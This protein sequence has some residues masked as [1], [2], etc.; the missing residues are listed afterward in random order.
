MIKL[1][2]LKNL[3][4]FGLFDSLKEVFF[5]F[6]IFLID[7]MFYNFRGIFYGM[8]VVGFIS[9]DGFFYIKLI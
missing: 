6:N 5:D 7:I 4:N 1:V 2:I 3:I 8:W 9:G